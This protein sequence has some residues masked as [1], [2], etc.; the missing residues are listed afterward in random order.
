[1]KV[2]TFSKESVGVFLG[3]VGQDHEILGIPEGGGRAVAREPVDQAVEP[4]AGHLVAMEFPELLDGLGVGQAFE[5]IAPL[6][7]RARVLTLQPLTDEQMTRVIE[8]AVTD[9]ERGLGEERVQLEA[10]ALQFLLDVASGDA[11]VALNAVEISAQ[12]APVGSDGARPVDRALIEEV[13]QRRS[14]MYDKGG[15]SHYDTISAFIKSMRA[16]DPDAAVYWL[17]RMIEA[18]EDPLFIAR[19]IVILKISLG[20]DFAQSDNP[21]GRN[22]QFLFPSGKFEHFQ[23]NQVDVSGSQFS[24]RT[25]HIDPVEIFVIGGCLLT[26]IPFKLL[27]PEIPATCHD[28]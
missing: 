8:T 20:D 1:M 4:V 12:I 22:H 28:G 2:E 26:D 5:V 27:Q 18:G 23:V 25:K 19:R 24:N 21:F 9:S 7:S 15:D 13:L 14:P 16:S 11:R 10:E 6:L 17:V 3:V